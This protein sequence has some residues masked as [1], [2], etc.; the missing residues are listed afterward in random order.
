MSASRSSSGVEKSSSGYWSS[1][2]SE[3]SARTLVSITADDISSEDSSARLLSSNVGSSPSEKTT[4]FSASSAESRSSA[5]GKS[6][7][8]K[9]TEWKSDGGNKS[10]VL[11]GE[12]VT[13]DSK[14]E[15]LESNT[16]QGEK[17]FDVSTY[18]V[19]DKSLLTQSFME[20]FGYHPPRELTPVSLQLPQYNL[21]STILASS[22]LEEQTD[23]S[24]CKTPSKNANDEV[25]HD[26]RNNDLNSKRSLMSDL[27]Y[28]N[29]S[30]MG[31]LAH[32]DN[33]KEVSS[34]NGHSEKSSNDLE[35]F[36]NEKN[37]S[38]ARAQKEIKKF[39]TKLQMEQLPVATRPFSSNSNSTYTVKNARSPIPP[40]SRTAYYELNDGSDDEK[41]DKKQSKE[42]NEDK[43]YMES[44]SESFPKRS[45][46][47][48]Q[49]LPK[50]THSTPY[51]DVDPPRILHSASSERYEFPS[52]Q[53]EING[54]G[55]S[56][57]V[58]GYE[59]KSY[60]NGYQ[61]SSE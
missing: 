44:K 38:L 41:D 14:S 26:S 27:K 46:V 36:L 40:V 6:L 10:K 5:A 13:K 3:K 60:T 48:E 52:Q 33:G 1:S 2:K 32:L 31:S 59:L 12:N 43:C 56:R 47:L 16:F 24:V 28:Q 30:R 58:D 20:N 35:K 4:P 21:P 11:D 15:K 39:E 57:E 22:S 51:K 7:K 25:S 8:W 42:T 49:S 53:K 18:S 23:A 50:L 17:S 37:D 55:P 19:N 9:E 54:I 29:G 61:T 45:A 34:S